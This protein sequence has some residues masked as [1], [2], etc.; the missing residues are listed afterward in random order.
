V[1][2]ACQREWSRAR[3][4][5]EVG[6]EGRSREREGG[7]WSRVW[8]GNRPSQGERRVSL[9]SKFLFLFLY[10]FSFEQLIN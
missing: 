6:R 7:E 5:P 8:A 4:G 9:F 3:S 1:G 2:T 10:P